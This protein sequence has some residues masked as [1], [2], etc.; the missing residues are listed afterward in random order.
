MSNINTST[1]ALERRPASNAK[2]AIHNKISWNHG[3]ICK[4][5]SRGV[6]KLMSIKPCAQ[7]QNWGTTVRLSAPWGNC[8]L[9]TPR[10]PHTLA[11]GAKAADGWRYWGALATR[12]AWLGNT[13][14]GGGRQGPGERPP[15]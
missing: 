11:D 9:G 4:A 2:Y 13:F 15:T 3:K 10:T 8:K 5:S 1:A 12:V 6:R 14:K 7:E